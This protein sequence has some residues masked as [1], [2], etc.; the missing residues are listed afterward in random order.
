YVQWLL[1]ALAGVVRV[2]S[3]D[4]P[5]VGRGQERRAQQQ[6]QDDA[7]HGELRFSPG[8]AGEELSHLGRSRRVYEE[9][10][11]LGQFDQWPWPLPMCWPEIGRAQCRESGEV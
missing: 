11:P 6:S 5:G 1:G 2:A 3:S 8:D 10:G 4:H 9:A 7:D